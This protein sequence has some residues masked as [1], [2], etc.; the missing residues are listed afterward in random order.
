MTPFGNIGVAKVLIDNVLEGLPL[1]NLVN[2][3][4]GKLKRDGVGKLIRTLNFFHPVRK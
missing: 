4:Q 1:R 2:L 3:T